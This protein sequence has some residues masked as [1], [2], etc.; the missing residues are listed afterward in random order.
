MTSANRDWVGLLLAHG[1][2]CVSERLGAGGMGFVYRA[3]DGNLGCDVVIKA[4][5]PEMLKDGDFAARFVREI[6][7]LVRLAHPHIVNVIDVGAHEG[8]PFAVLKYLPGGS[9]R[10]RQKRDPD[11]K[12]LPMP[13]RQLHT[14]LGGVAAALDFIHAQQHVHRDVKPDNI[15]FDAQGHVYLGDFG[16]VKVLADDPG[17]NKK[18]VLTSLG[19]V[20]GT[21]QYMAPEILLGRRY[22][23]RVDQYALAVV[24]YELLSG[25]FP[26]DGDLPAQI[27][28][29]HMTG[30][31]PRLEELVPKLPAAVAAAVRRAMAREPEERFAD[32]AA[33]ARAV[34]DGLGAAASEALACPHCKKRLKLPSAAAGKQVQCPSCRKAFRVPAG[35]PSGPEGPTASVR[36]KRGAGGR[37]A[38]VARKP[39]RRG[40]RLLWAALAAV[41]VVAAGAAALATGLLGGGQEPPR[42]VAQVSNPD[43]KKATQPAGDKQGREKPPPEA[44]VQPPVPKPEPPVQPEVPVQKQAEPP[45]QVEPRTPKQRAPDREGPPEIRPVPRPPPAPEPPRFPGSGGSLV[46]AWELTAAVWNLTAAARQPPAPPPPT[47]A[48]GEA[49][50]LTGHT[51]PVY[52]V[53]CS[54]DGKLALSG[55]GT[56]NPA[57]GQ[58]GE[59]CELRLWD[60]ATGQEVRQFAGHTQ[61]V[62]AVAFSPDGKLAVSGSYDKTVRLWDVA[63]GKEVR[64]LTGNNAPV[65]AVAFSP[66]GRYLLSGSSDRRARLWDVETG[67]ELREF[68]G[69]TELVSSVAFSPDGRR[70]LT[71]SHD[72]TVRLWDLPSGAEL[73]RL[74]GHADLVWAVA[75]APDGKQ[76]LSASGGRLKGN[77]VGPGTDYGLRLWDLEGEAPALRLPPQAH[78]VNC[79]AFSPDGK[80]AVWGGDDML[81]HV[82]DL[83]AGKELAALGKDVHRGGVVGLALSP[84]GSRALACSDRTVHVWKLAGAPVAVAAKKVEDPEL[85]RDLFEGHK[86]NVWAVAVAPDGRLALSAGGGTNDNQRGKDHDVLLWDPVTLRTLARLEGHTD[87][88]RAAAVTRKGRLAATAGLD[89]TVRLWD[90]PGRK[91]AGTLTLRG[92]QPLG[93]IVALAFTPD[94]K[95]LVTGGML[96]VLWDVRTRAA[97]RFAA[98]AVFIYSV[99]VSPNG[100]FLLSGAAD[101]SV[102]LWS[103]KTHRE[104]RPFRGHTSRV[105]QV[106]FS[107]DGKRAFTVSG[108]KIVGGKAEPGEDDTVRVWEVSTGKQ[109]KRIDSTNGAFE[110]GALSP[111]GRLLA[112]GGPDAVVRLWDLESGREVTAFRG[113]RSMVTSV[114]FLPNGRRLLSASRDGTVRVWQLPEQA[115]P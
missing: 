60:L 1:R 55:G 83:A 5:R 82:W 104:V 95:Q 21:P 15:L 69:H 6:R 66:G 23:G 68:A 49:H 57:P 64:T 65:Y 51:R 99:A 110:C 98:P 111:D 11:G 46:S 106:G 20:L 74:A 91:P 77:T 40:R 37:P 62:R 25:R 70:V 31:A 102:R 59:G 72:T 33:F 2:Y 13:A 52:C 39:V 24:V 47:A 63:S 43:E 78:P 29:A 81:L 41:V 22:D 79:A 108:W 10:S 93:Q 38:P 54:P 87:I 86:E 113:H 84:D 3:H 42:R 73:R 58:A 96:L 36:P 75:F 94:D 100:G 32:C 103:L 28:E 67:A 45:P 107:A 109:L 9:L 80:R 7:S 85:V 48:A 35:G 71:G 88:V 16:I 14:W 18:T 27:F 114:A 90:V 92:P 53:A 4:P 30:T 89:A 17:H 61:L 76:A 12:P 112:T 56:F 8:A 50:R 101:G 26:F 44:P 97:Y 34:L 19:T 105:A 115:A